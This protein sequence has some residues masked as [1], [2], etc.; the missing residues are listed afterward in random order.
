MRAVRFSCVG[1]R[2][3]VAPLAASLVFAA[4][5]AAG[6]PPLALTAVTSVETLRP[7]ESAE[8]TLEVAIADGW[9]INGVDP[10]L[11]FLIPT[12]VAFELPSGLRADDVRY[13][14]PETRQL[15]IAGDNPL[16]LYRG[17]IS[18]HAT[19]SY[20]TGAHADGSRR[21]AAVLRYQACNDTVCLRPTTATVELPVRLAGDASS[22]SPH[23]GG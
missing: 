11:S 13:P 1:V 18:I 12:S 16:R 20:D 4:L 19:L 7:G 6:P 2:S 9:H 3:I 8:V 21:L 15:K 17:N 5:V 22:P 10:G 23:R 14:P